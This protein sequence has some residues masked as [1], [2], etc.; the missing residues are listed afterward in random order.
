MATASTIDLD[1]LLAP[2][3]G[4]NPSGIDLR[5]D[6]AYEEIKAARPKE[7]RDLLGTDEPQVANW[8]PVVDLCAAAIARQTKDLLVAGWLTEALVHTQGFAGL[9]DGLRLVR[10]LIE[11]FWDT[12]YPLPD[13]GD[14]EPRVAPIVWLMEPDRGAKLTIA[15]RELP[16]TPD[17][18][19]VFSWNYWN[20]LTLRPRSE[21]E[22]EEAYARRQ[23]EG[24]ERSR[25]WQEAITRLSREFVVDLLEDISQAG[26][27]L[28]GL[29]KLCDEKFAKL[30]PGIGAMRQAI[31]ECQQRV[32]KIK[33]ERFGDDETA[34]G[35]EE[36]ASG[37]G[38][39]ATGRGSGPIKDREDAFRRLAEAAAY[40]RLTEPHS[41]LPGLIDA[42][43]VW[44][45][46]PFDQVMA[47]LIRNIS[48]QE[49]L[50][51][52]RSASE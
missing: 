42:T 1:A 17:R 15:L 26:E 2:I 16:L 39:A 49:I 50:G 29:D 13:D 8:A 51:I 11:N 52:G 10:G 25:A 7:D 48:I 6:P 37:N 19:T 44:G 23:V 45:R 31:A 34:A 14:L 47:D 12:L 30:A 4:D 5:W 40:F 35:E 3:A 24:E 41:P 9:R 21:N 22:T 36:Q 20:S 18:E 43:V 46:K 27:A 33:L 28:A 32:K 38:R